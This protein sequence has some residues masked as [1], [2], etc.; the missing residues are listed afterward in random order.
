MN[1]LHL[2]IGFLEWF[3]DDVSSETFLSPL[4]VMPVAL[5]R[6]TSRGGQD[7]Y[8][9][10]ALDSAPSTNLSLELRLRD[11]FGLRIPDFDSDSNYPIEDYLDGVRAMVTCSIHHGAFAVS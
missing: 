7:D 5:E 4:L 6:T 1:T 8:R 9:L 3:E 2:A 11:D 10:T